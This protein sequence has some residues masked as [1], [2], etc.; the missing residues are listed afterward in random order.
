MKWKTSILFLFFPQAIASGTRVRKTESKE[1]KFSC[2]NRTYWMLILTTDFFLY[3]TFYFLHLSCPSGISPM[4]NLGCLLQGKSTTMVNLPNLQ[5]MLSI[6]VFPCRSDRLKKYNGT[7]FA[8]LLNLLSQQRPITRFP[9]LS[10]HIQLTWSG[11]SFLQ[12]SPLC[13]LLA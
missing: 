10:K 4:V 3:F 1:L 12:P 7:I 2:F 6:W 9:C 11:S 5:S 8:L 13:F